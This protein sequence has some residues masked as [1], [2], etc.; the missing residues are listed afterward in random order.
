VT[1]PPPASPPAVGAS[2]PPEAPA[3]PPEWT[4]AL[5]AV[6]AARVTIVIGA[7]DA[8][9][10][11]LVGRLARRLASDEPTAVVDADVGQ[12][13]IGPPG[14]VGLAHVRDPG[15]P[16]DAAPVLALAFVGVTSPAQDVSGTV[17]ATARLVARARQEGFARVLVDTSG[18]VAGGLGRALKR[19]KIAA[20]DPDLV[21]C[22]QRADECEHI[23]ASLADRARPRIVRLAALGTRI[24]RSAVER[25]LRRQRRLAAPFVGARPVAL[26]LDRIRLRQPA[27]GQGVRLSRAER[28][29]AAA[30][31]DVP[32]AWAERHAD[33]VLVVTETAADAAR[34]H[35]LERCLQRPVKA[36]ARDA[37][38]GA[39]ASLETADGETIALAVVQ[40]LDLDRRR[41][42]V[43]T[44]SAAPA[45]AAIAIGRVR[46]ATG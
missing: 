44:T 7:S 39:L 38:E 2:A 26:D 20:L 11:T 14:T 40:R 25:R 35:E 42:D 45:V 41:I 37:L 1:D 16:I 28:A 3:L 34:L 5:P 8:G 23:L 22:V 30:V 4:P 27:L 31:L 29:Q 17:A 18:L 43:L 15:A 24:G 13:E 36:W 6:R 19:A 12:S 32:V 46:V 33:H 21:L 9:K 10:T